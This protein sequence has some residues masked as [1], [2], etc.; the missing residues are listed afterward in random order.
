MSSEQFSSVEC[1]LTVAGHVVREVGDISF[2][3]ELNAPFALTVYCVLELGRNADGAAANRGLRYRDVHLKLERP[4]QEDSAMEIRGLV[5][6]S[7]YEMQPRDQTNDD[8]GRHGFTLEVVPALALLEHHKDKPQAW[9]NR[10]YAYVLQQV[11]EE[12]LAVYGR[13]VK[14][15][16]KPGPTIPLI[17]R[18]PGESAL[19]FVQRLMYESGINSYFEH[20]AGTSELLVLVNDNASFKAPKLPYDERVS[21]TNSEG[22]NFVT[23]VRYSAKSGSSSATFAGFDPVQ[24]PNLNIGQFG[25]SDA[26]LPEGAKELRW[27]SVRHG[28]DAS[29]D[30]PFKASAELFAERAATEQNAFE[31]DTSILG[32]LAG[33]VMPMDEGGKPVDAVVTSTSFQRKGGGFMAKSRATPTRS[34]SGESINVRA[35]ME[36]PP[37]EYQGLTLARVASSGAAVDVDGRLWCKI[38]FVWDTEGK[39]EPQ[40]RAPVMQ[41]MAGAYGGTQWIP[42]KGDVVIVAFL[43]GSRENPVI[44]GCQYDAKQSP[45]HI[46]P[47]DTPGHMKSEAKSGA[48]SQLP[49]SASWLGWSYSS[50][51]GSRPSSNARTMFAMNVAE[52]S[53]LLYL[54]APR[55]YR[56]DVTRNADLWV[57]GEATEKVEGKLTE[58]VGAEYAQKVGGTSTVEVAAAYSL[59]AMQGTLDFMGPLGMSAAGGMT[60]TSTGAMLFNAAS[61]F[62]NSPSIGF[63]SKPSVG[64]G[65]GAATGETS[66]KLE[67]RAELTAPQAVEISSGTSMLETQPQRVRVESSAIELNSG[68]GATTKL[69]NGRVVVEA[70]Q[71]IVFRCGDVELS[72]SK[73]GIEISGTKLQIKIEGE[74][75]VTSD[76]IKLEGESLSIENDQTRIAAKRLD[77]SD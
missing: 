19:S 55:D 52:G 30:G 50:I 29:P 75:V 13:K 59:S 5:A 77:I 28:D 31:F 20:D 15:S 27:T 37:K 9:H 1:T 32:G 12:E 22:A 8:K 10:T 51:A 38:K 35:P 47:S 23:N 44:I 49:A 56:V 74:T 61:F 60:S 65:M 36:R 26:S 4:R 25:M 34:P 73:K 6:N 66:L 43:E 58:E 46:G 54:N 7:F 39:D 40:T 42:R 53:E 11:L 72:L 64:G 63:S 76:R 69:E 70:D 2:E 16:A 48:G 18:S 68:G 14:N 21:L 67:Q 17:T 24:S 41:P 62:V 45:L 71:G 3:E 33:R 57:K